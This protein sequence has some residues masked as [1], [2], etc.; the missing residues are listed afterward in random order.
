MTCNA[1]AESFS[2]GNNRG[3]RLLALLIKTSS[4]FAP[5]TPTIDRWK[6]ISFH[7]TR[8][9]RSSFLKATAGRLIRPAFG[10]SLLVA[11][12]TNLATPGFTTYTD[13]KFARGFGCASPPSTSGECSPRS[14]PGS[15]ASS[16]PACAKR[17]AYS[18]PVPN[19]VQHRYFH[20]PGRAA[21]V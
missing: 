17:S 3:R 7:Q 19:F 13:P 18:N 11:F 16:S 15:T 1:A 21:R 14:R 2:F 12:L 6:G 4:F 9:S 8:L 10:R 20:R 5:A